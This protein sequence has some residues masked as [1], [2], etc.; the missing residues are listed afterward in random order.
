MKKILSIVTILA[1]SSFSANSEILSIGLSGTLG[2]LNADGTSAQ[3]GTS[4]ASGTNGN[5]GGAETATT[6][7]SKRS[8]DNMAFGYGSIFMEFHLG[9]HIR[10]GVDYVPMKL[11]SETTEKVNAKIVSKEFQHAAA[12]QTSK[13]GTTNNVQVDL[14]DLR[15]LYASLYLNSFYLKAGIMEGDL[16]T[17]EKMGTGSSYGNTTLEGTVIALGYER[18]LDKGYFVRG[19]VQQLE[20]DNITLKSTGSENTTTI[21]VK[22]MEGMSGMLSVG[23]SF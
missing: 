20:L 11:E 14:K 10:L 19:E 7:N 21:N 12:Y 23:K 9:D 5:S 22:G 13:A 6:S 16:I 18:S 1:F 15:T 8:E 2:V 4:T 17:N 3:A